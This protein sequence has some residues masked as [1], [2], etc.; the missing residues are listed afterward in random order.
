[1]NA[2]TDTAAFDNEFGTR[3]GTPMIGPYSVNQM[4]DFY[5]ALARGEVKATGI[6]NYLQRLF[7]AE[8]V[9][10]GDR[11]VDVCCGRGLQLPPDQPARSP[12]RFR[13]A[14]GVGSRAFVRKNAC[15]NIV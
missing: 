13:K 11:I 14:P 9:R 3:P 12:I 10:P 15:I 8:R 6:M 1:M 5:V 4:D 7:I 2:V